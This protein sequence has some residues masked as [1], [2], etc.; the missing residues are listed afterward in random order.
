ML[1][2]EK[3]MPNVDVKANYEEVSREFNRKL[4][5]GQNLTYDERASTPININ[6]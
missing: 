5:M 1:M 6:F 4:A 3:P 2:F